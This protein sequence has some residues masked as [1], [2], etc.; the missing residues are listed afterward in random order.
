MALIFQQIGR[1]AVG[2]G[3]ICRPAHGTSVL[4]LI[5][6][7]KLARPLI[8]S[9]RRQ[10]E[11]AF[12]RFSCFSHQHRHPCGLK[13]EEFVPRIPHSFASLPPSSAFHS[14]PVIGKQIMSLCVNLLHHHLTKVTVRKLVEG[15]RLIVMARMEQRERQQ[16]HGNVHCNVPL[17]NRVFILGHP[18]AILIW[19]P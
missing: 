4:L 12:R 5:G 2:S 8:T 17:L 1:C 15:G 16:A 11:R 10:A 13:S 19:T 18:P 6:S 14:L 9:L 3:G 7:T